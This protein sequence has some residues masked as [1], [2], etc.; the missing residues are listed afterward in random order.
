LKLVLKKGKFTLDKASG[1]AAATVLVQ[2]KGPK[3][4][5]F[6][7]KK[8]FKVYKKAGSS[9]AVGTVKKNAEFSVKKAAIIDKKV[10][11]SVAAGKT[12]GWVKLTGKIMVKQKGVNM[13]G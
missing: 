8:S 2:G 7:A 13:W 5:G 10:Y 4:A 3:P 1:T 9:K 11:V 12:K 6:E